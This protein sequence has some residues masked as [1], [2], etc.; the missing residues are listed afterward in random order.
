MEM[1]SMG[2]A[3]ADHLEAGAFGLDADEHY[4][5]E[6]S[7]LGMKATGFI[8]TIAAPASR[9]STA[10]TKARLPVGAR[11]A[12]EESNPVHL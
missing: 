9:A 5:R 2:Y 6:P 8:C 11:L 7:L 4:L 10:P 1:N 12:R 3:E